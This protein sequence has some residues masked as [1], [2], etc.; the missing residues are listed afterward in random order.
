MSEVTKSS[1]AN[2]PSSPRRFFEYL[3]GN[4]DRNSS[5]S[6]EISSSSP[7]IEDKSRIVNPICENRVE[8][9]HLL[10]SFPHTIVGFGS[11]SAPFSMGFSAFLA[12]RRRKEGRPRRQRTTFSSEQTLR[13]EVEFHKNEYISR[14]KRFELA[15]NLQLTETQIKIWFQNRRA[16]DKRIEKAQ[17]DQQYRTFI[18]ANRIIPPFNP[19]FS[20]PVLPH[21]PVLPS[22]HPR[23]HE[24]VTCPESPSLQILRGH[25]LNPC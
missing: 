2:R 3:Y 6:S 11:E 16:K 13:L 17:I 24:I 14:G 21:P 4:L 7:D 20:P 8:F 18:A 22:F 23:P 9:S 5:S 19:S 25:P 1:C 10:P 12:R 15:E